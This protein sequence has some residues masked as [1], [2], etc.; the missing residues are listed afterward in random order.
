MERAK[1]REETVRVIRIAR[2]VLFCI[3][4]CVEDKSFESLTVVV[5][6]VGFTIHDILVEALLEIA[7]TLLIL[8]KSPLVFISCLV[9]LLLYVLP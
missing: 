1:R 4:C 6:I 8:V 2:I 3:V 9:T 7:V 5:I